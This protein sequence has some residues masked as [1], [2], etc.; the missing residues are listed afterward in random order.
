[1][2]YFWNPSGDSL[3]E[4]KLHVFLQEFLQRFYKN[5][6]N[7]EFFQKFLRRFPY[8]FFPSSKT[9]PWFLLKIS[10]DFFRN[11]CMDYFENNTRDSF[12]KSSFIKSSKD[13]S[14]QFLQWV[15]Q[16]FCADSFILR[17]ASLQISP[18]IT[19]DLEWISSTIPPGILVDRWKP[20]PGFFFLEIPLA[21][22]SEILTCSSSLIPSRTILDVFLWNPLEISE[23]LSQDF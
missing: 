10:H 19:Y 13:S 18:K 17:I 23:R 12:R 20:P 1:M 21:V 8:K 5:I 9:C 3:E 15:L 14:G 22:S 11:C 4:K 7:Y 2:D 16:I 6:R